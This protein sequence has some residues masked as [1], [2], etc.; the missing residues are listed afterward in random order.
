MN[1]LN[2][3]P[4]PLFPKWYYFL[5]GTWEFQPVCFLIKSKFSATSFI[6]TIFCH[7]EM[8]ALALSF[9]LLSTGQLGEF[10]LEYTLIFLTALIKL[11]V[12]PAT[13]S[14]FLFAVLPLFF[15]PPIYIKYEYYLLSCSLITDLNIFC[16]LVCYKTFPKVMSDINKLV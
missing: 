9:K 10:S 3:N 4:S 11:T 7:L 16:V 6:I 5:L 14:V 2:K 1:Y 15:Y 8:K 12:Q 13:V